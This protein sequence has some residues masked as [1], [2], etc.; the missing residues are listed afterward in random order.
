MRILLDFLHPAH[1]HVFRNFRDAMLQRG[2]EVVVTARDKD[3]TLDLLDRYGI[4][5]EVLSTQKTG[6]LGMAGELLGR[7][8]RL[9]RAAR[10]VRPDV[11]AGIMGPS[12]APAGRLLRIP[13]VV[14]YDTEFATRTNRWVYPMA[15]AVVTPDCYQGRVRGRHITYPGYHELAYLHADRFDPD[16]GMVA[17]LGVGPDERYSVVRF[18]SWQASHDAGERALT[19]DQKR[20]I[21]ESLAERG[22]VFVSSEA[23]LPEDLMAHR[24][25]TPP[26]AIHHVLAGA[27]VVVGESATMAS[28]AAVLGV[29]AVFVA[30]TGRGYTEEQERRYR[31]VRHVQPDDLAAVLGAITDYLDT[32]IDALDERRARLLA[33]KVDVTAWM[34]DFFERRGW[35]PDPD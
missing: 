9:V 8:R 21:V 31:L 24:L 15:T 22:P 26:E 20:R 4:P 27:A 17:R 28:E 23:P 34:V 16:P 12:I 1:V 5:A 14:F 7:T 13:S 35:E 18:V 33:D 2:H 19:A 32:P 29:P 6:A 30:T 3:L 25:P 11:L 10:R